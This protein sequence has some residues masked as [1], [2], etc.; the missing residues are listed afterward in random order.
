MLDF[1]KDYYLCMLVL[2]VVSYL[3]PKEEYKAYIQF[4][5]GIFIIVLLL[6]PILTVVNRAGS[7]GVYQLFEEFSASLDGMHMQMEEREG[8][9]EH[10]FAAPGETE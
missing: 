4:F 1:F 8:L 5:I 7:D 6:Q 3:V 2:M 9:F 10:F